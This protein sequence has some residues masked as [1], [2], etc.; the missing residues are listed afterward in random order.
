MTST[1]ERMPY[2]VSFGRASYGEF[3]TF[4]EALVCARKNR[5]IQS[6]VNLNEADGAPDASPRAQAGLTRAE[7]AVLEEEGFV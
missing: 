5:P 4:G 2:R 6:F 7:W 3:Q 1:L